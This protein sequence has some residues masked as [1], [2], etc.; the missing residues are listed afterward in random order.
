MTAPSI[1]TVCEVAAISYRQ[2]DYWDRVGHLGA[3]MGNGS[4]YHRKFDRD[5][6]LRILVMAEMAK[7]FSA[8]DRSTRGTY[9]AK[10]TNLVRSL[11][12]LNAPPVL[13]VEFGAHLSLSLVMVD[14]LR[15]VEDTFAREAA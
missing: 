7:A 5:R 3:P 15:V 8:S 11:T 13:Y 12:V 1:T 9:P 6:F 10:V 4:G 14:L 2:L